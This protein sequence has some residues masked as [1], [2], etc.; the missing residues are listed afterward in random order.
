MPVKRTRRS[1]PPSD[2]TTNERLKRAKLAG[3]DFSNWGW[4]GNEVTDASQIT[5]EHK[6]VACGLS[7]YSPYPLCPNKNKYVKPD[8]TIPKKEKVAAGELED[9]IIVISDDESAYCNAK[10]CR[11]NPNCLNHIGQDKWE[12]EGRSVSSIT[13]HKP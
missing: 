6:L 8:G 10:S 3:N 13:A 1:P 7:K 12:A 9:D 5:Q 11:N 4:V 2:Q